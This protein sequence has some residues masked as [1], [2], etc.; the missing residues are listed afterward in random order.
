MLDRHRK[1]QPQG[2]N[3]LASGFHGRFLEFLR[4]LPT[5]E[6]KPFVVAF[7]Q[8]TLSVELFAPRGVDTQKPHKQDEVYVVVRG[9]GT[10]FDGA[11]RHRFEPGDLLFVPAG[12]E[13]RFEDFTDN[14]AVW[15]IFYG[16]ESG[17]K[18]V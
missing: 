15:V 12:V 14:F 4:K 2:G 7:E 16:P 3:T 5:P 6:G 9:E 11:A 18:P 10:F 17:E 1:G 8:G 13:H